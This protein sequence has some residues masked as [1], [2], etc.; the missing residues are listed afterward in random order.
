MKN[1]IYYLILSLLV[2]FTSC[3]EDTIEENGIGKLTGTVVAK[4]SNEPLENIKI[5]T[6]PA[7]STVFTD[8]SGN[9]VIENISVGDYSVQ[10][11]SDEYADSFEAVTILNSK[12]STVVFELEVSKS[13]NV[14]P[15]VPKLLTPVDGTSDL[16]PTVKFVWSSSKNDTDDI[17]YTLQLRNG[18]TNEIQL[19]E[20]VADTTIIIENLGLGTNYFWQISASDDNSDPVQSAV[21]QFSTSTT[22]Q[23][24]YFYVR[25]VNGNSVI[26]SGSENDS[27]GDDSE[28][29]FN[30]FKLTSES[31]NSFRPH[32]NV[33]TS[34][35]AF[36]R[37]INGATQL[38]TMNVDGSA[39]KQ[40]TSS[41]PVNGFRI[42]ELD[43]TWAQSGGKLYYPN[44][45]KLYSV[46]P[47]GGGSTLIY[48]TADGSFI[49]EV[50]TSDF[51]DN[52]IVIKTNNSA[53]YN[54]RVYTVRLSSGTEERVIFQNGTGAVKGI[55]LNANG[56][57]LVYSK[58]T[59]GSQNDQYRQFASRIYIYNLNTGV[60]R[61]LDNGPITGSN[62]I[63]PRWSP[64][65]GE[66]IF[67]RKP[68][69]INSEPKVL[70]SPLNDFT[71]DNVLFTNAAMPDWED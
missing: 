59:S 29:N 44:F 39:V 22:P 47:D 14:K 2:V 68:S 54:V 58:D 13:T 24:S 12:T 67:V 60:E 17:T 70:V 63:Q 56:T 32:K 15:L 1:K 43:Y 31:F 36:L 66:I 26:F 42:D 8:A 19:Q 16:D 6:S 25:S 4:S 64:S 52:L 9:F 69:N 23:N 34:K 51:D 5:V 10:A 71:S 37:T 50:S 40:V 57:Q 33:E 62:D 61:L 27:S 28:V 3:S 55:D 18:S 41:I 30:E 35:I 20:V 46:N 65:E 21:S 45:D 49:S 7:S 48:T 53:G 38:H 11:E